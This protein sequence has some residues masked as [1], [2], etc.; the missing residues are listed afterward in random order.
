MISWCVFPDGYL[1][2]RSCGIPCVCQG[3][4]CKTPHVIHEY[5]DS[6][7]NLTFEEIRDLALNIAATDSIRSGGN[8]WVFV[9]DRFTA[10]VAENRT[11]ERVAAMNLLDGWDGHFVNGG[12]D[13]WVSGVDRADAWM[14]TN[15]WIHE[16]ARLTF[17]DELGQAIY[18]AQDITVL[19]NVFLH[20]LKGLNSGIG[21]LPHDCPGS[22]FLFG[23]PLFL[24]KSGL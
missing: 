10:A 17:E 13:M 9:E 2:N 19:F 1:I 8:P 21:P 11:D 18:E 6:H 7:D 12:S 3:G 22:N 14:L 4:V 24:G 15:A 23:N 5:L 20:G 16:V